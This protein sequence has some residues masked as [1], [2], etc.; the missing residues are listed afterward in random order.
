MSGIMSQA[1]I[2]TFV[3]NYLADVL[4]SLFID[5]PFYQMFIYLVQCAVLAM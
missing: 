5:I 1:S 4:Y 3:T 2:G